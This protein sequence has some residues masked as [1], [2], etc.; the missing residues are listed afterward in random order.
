MKLLLD[1][2]QVIWYKRTNWVIPLEMALISG[3]KEVN[4]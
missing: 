2:Q 4:T 1:K 3:E